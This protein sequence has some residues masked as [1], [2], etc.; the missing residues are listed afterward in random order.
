MALGD[1]ALDNNVGANWAEEETV[2]Y[3]DGDYGTP[4]WENG[5][6]LPDTDPPY[7]TTTSPSDGATGVDVGTNVSATFNEAIDEG[8]LGFS[9]TGPGGDLP[10]SVSYDPGSYTATF[11]PD[12]DLA[13]ETT[14]TARIAAGLQ[15][16]S[17]NPTGSDY[18]W[19]FTTRGVV[20][21]PAIVINEIMQNPA[22]VADSAGEWFEL[23]NAGAE[24][25]DIDGWTIQDNGSD[26][27]TIDN[28]GPLEI[29]PGEYLVLGNNA[30][31]ATNGGAEVDYQYPGD[32]YLANGDDEI[33]LLDAS[34]NEIDRVEYDDGATFPDPNGASMALGDPALDNNVGANWAEEET[35]QYGDGDYGT[36]GWENGT[37]LPDTDPP[38]VVS[39][40][41]DAGQTNVDI[42]AGVSAVF[43]EAIDEG[44]LGFTLAGPGGDVPGS[45]SYDP[46]SY[47]ATFH[48]ASPLD[49]ETTYTARI[50]AG[51]QDL[52]D[53]A[54]AEDYTWSFTTGGPAPPA[55]VLISEVQVR[56]TDSASDEF[57]EL[58]NPSAT[59]SFNLNGYRIGYQS[60]SGSIGS[61]YTWSEDAFIPPH[62]H[63]LLVNSTAYDGSVPGDVSYSTGLADNGAIAIVRLSDDEIVDSVGWGDVDPTVVT[64]VETASAPGPGAE[65]S[66]ERLPGGEAGNGQDTH[67]NSAD[68]AVIDPPNPQNT[69]S[70]P[71]PAV[72][73]QI[74]TIAEARAEPDGTQVLVEGIAT[75]P[76]GIY[77]AGGGNTKFYIQDATGGAQIQ[78]FGGNGP[79]P[80]VTLGDR[81]RVSGLTG[82][83]RDEF[84]IVPQ[85]NAAD[86][87]ITDGA[88][89]D[90]P[91]PVETAIADVG[92]G[93]EGWLIALE[94]LVI[95]AWHSGYG[96]NVRLSD[97]QGHE[98]QLYIDDMTGIDTTGIVVGLVQRFVGISS[99]YDDRYETKPRI[100]E[101]V[102][103]WP[104]QQGA[105]PAPAATAPGPLL[106]GAVHYDTLYPGYDERA[107]A[108]QLINT[109]ETAISLAGYHLS[110]NETSVALPDLT[111][112]AGQKAWLARD[113]AR[114]TLEFG[115]APAWS[116]GSLAPDLLFDNRGDET[117]LLD[118][119]GAVVDALVIENGCAAEQSGWNE[120]GGLYPYLFASYVATEGQI[121]YRELD[122]L[123]GRPVPDTDTLADWAQDPANGG[124]LRYPGW[125]LDQFFFPPQ[126][127][128]EATTTLLVAPDNLYEGLAALIAEAQSTIDIELYRFVHPTLADELVAAMDRGVQV[129]LLME[130]EAYRAP[131]GTWD[132]ARWVAQQVYEHP[133]GQAYF[134]RDATDDD[135]VRLADRYN[136][137]HQKFILVDGVKAAV[138]SE[139][140]SQNP[141]P[142]DDKSDGTAGNRGAGVI[143]TAPGVVA[144]LQ[145]VFAADFD[146]ANHR[147]ID[148]FTPGR[149]DVRYEEGHEGEPLVRPETLGNR[150]GYT[151]VHP[152]PLTLTDLVSFEVVQSPETS[153]RAADALLGMVARADGGDL[154]LVQQQYEH[155][156]WGPG[157]D[158]FLNPRLTAY[159]EA[160]RRGAA[161]RIM[162]SDNESNTYEDELI[163]YLNDLAA[164]EG[165]DLTAGK[166]TPTAGT[167]DGEPFGGHIHNK[168]VLVYDGDTQGWAHIGS[169]NGSENSS[170]YNREMA[171][172]IG[173][174]QAF[175]YYAEVFHA[176]WTAS[177]LPPFWGAPVASFEVSDATPR[178]GQEVLFTNT[179]SGSAP[180]F[181]EWD[182]GDGSPVSTEEH[183][184]HTFS[185][186]GVYQVTLRAVNAVGE[187][188]ATRELQVG[189]PPDAVFTARP[190]TVM[191]GGT[192]RFTNQSSGTEPLTYF[193]EFGDGAT[194]DE[195]NP[196]HAY[197]HAGVYTVRL[198]A[199][200]LWG[201]DTATA[202]ITV[203]QPLDRMVINHMIIRWHHAGDQAAFTL[204]GRLALPP[205]YDR[206]DLT[207]EIILS[208]EIGGQ[209]AWQKVELKAFKNLWFLTHPSG[210][211]G[212]GLQVKNMGIRWSRRE[213]EEAAQFLVIGTLDL[214]G[215][216]PDTDPPEATIKLKLLAEPG[217]SPV[218]GREKIGFRRF[219]VWWHYARGGW[220]DLDASQVEPF[221]LSTW[222]W[223][224]WANDDPIE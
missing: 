55:P 98:T 99:Q 91:P 100:Q 171:L 97:D 62:G 82:H 150:T 90:V 7:V 160:A 43:N 47:T 57:I 149:D 88:P 105:C 135:G 116:Y 63:Y 222:D 113:A 189:Y 151:P 59:E 167:L 159:I 92:E 183:P 216:G 137:V 51:L 218:Y 163:Q 142:D 155:Q 126:V 143:T 166:G 115:F 14:Y 80:T 204:D 104:N 85:D 73:P 53:N 3:G 76:S 29:A 109:G 19:S 18:A 6:F 152:A 141:M 175:D 32:W 40:D 220:W 86:I 24:T 164:A 5:T 87:T 198:T 22:A 25:V 17:G 42:N 11:D 60:A 214:P 170:K 202:T 179:T 213:E 120:A 36:P 147:D 69:D 201:E 1:P 30:D 56:G 169:I 21:L 178:V 50:A 138:L 221:E 190:T 199:R 165:L 129:R 136:N 26:N 15:D 128:E 77:Y 131:G 16:L 148:P 72:G 114:F 215:L 119:S 127:E 224:E 209:T 172:Q 194:S 223:E 28:G 156:Y 161:V 35:V 153:L 34:L 68:F 132:D 61:R 31:P 121:L 168:M 70:P 176:D 65:Q 84:Q 145:A 106:I 124:K 205:S 174:D 188:T 13:P 101:D 192:V 182:F 146:P 39:T 20:P 54:M 67:D 108:V 52:S 210:G 71:T 139:N 89:E 93:S 38:T 206:Q 110:D 48:P 195:E 181:Y 78:V 45:V 33:V 83:Y 211:D 64:Y 186:P 122:E 196:T 37:F 154:V 191:P 173:S 112:A 123:T 157:G 212:Q 27:H 180:I 79:L 103:A 158:Q 185:Q 140:L 9:L 217:V 134:W 208:I 74:V 2:Q 66:I 4:G 193:W 133:N 8:T 187:S 96:T 207:R 107:E 58:Y 44:T 177:G 162:V 94:G 197:T 41:P 144:H 46:G 75:A 49:Y 10:G 117:V 130:G 12:A 23:Y 118:G 81:V 219:G 111:L 125:D 184:G 200:N 95:D 102:P 203:Y